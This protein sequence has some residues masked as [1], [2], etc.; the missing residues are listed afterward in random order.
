MPPLARPRVSVQAK[1]V[2]IVSELP[3]QQSFGNP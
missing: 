2:K 1:P 3:F